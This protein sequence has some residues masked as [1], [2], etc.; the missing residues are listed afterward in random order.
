MPIIIAIIPAIIKVFFQEK[1]IEI[2]LAIKG[3][4]KEEK[5]KNVHITLECLEEV[6]SE[7]IF[8]RG[9]LN[10]DKKKPIPP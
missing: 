4:A 10:I 5:E 6:F 7:I 2:T 8:T 9:P 1:N 3:P